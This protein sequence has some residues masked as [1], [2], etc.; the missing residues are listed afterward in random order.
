[1]KNGKFCSE[2][3]K[4]QIKQAVADVQLLKMRIAANTRRYKYDFNRWIFDSISI[5]GGETILELCCG[6][7]LQ[8]LKIAERLTT[9]VVYASDISQ[10]GINELMTRLPENM[11]SR[12]HPVLSDIDNIAG[13][14]DNIRPKRI[15]FDL[16][17]CF[18][19][20]YY[21]SNA[22]RV[23]N[24]L[25]RFLKPNG[26]IVI[27]GPYGENNTQLYSLFRRA[28]VRVPEFAIYTATRFME[29]VVLPFARKEFDF[30][31]TMSLVNTIYW[32]R[33]SEVIDYWKGTTSYY[34]ERTKVLKRELRNYFS[35]KDIFANDKWILLVQMSRKR[36]RARAPRMPEGRGKKSKIKVISL[37][38]AVRKK[39]LNVM[40]EVFRQMDPVYIKKG[41]DRFNES[42]HLYVLEGGN[43]YASLLFLTPV[44]MGRLVVGGVGGVATREKYRGNGYA[45]H[46]IRKAINDTKR[47]Y[48]AVLLW[49]RIP[50]FFTRFGFREVT[51]YFK[52]NRR[53]SVPMIYFHKPESEIF[54]NITK[55]LPRM[56]F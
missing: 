16:I 9:G 4:N 21:S 47:D 15:L 40:S 43:E 42:S 20:L 52:E 24:D 48:P 54:S 29:E 28:G 3:E 50:A 32:H 31:N 49:T 14:L 44:K 19:G 46:L 56:Y 37:T 53:G 33:P 2:A 30:V 41:M 7:G 1:M 5:S 26:R 36:E 6:N 17:F 13:T 38:P 35:K 23:L 55:R 25:K 51:K 22:T 45:T 12:V 11:A 10:K 8:T 18:Y 39:Y 34:P 27:I